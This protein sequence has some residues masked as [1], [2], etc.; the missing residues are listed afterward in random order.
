MSVISTWSMT[1]VD[2]T[3]VANLGKDMIIETLAKDGIIPEDDVEI[4]QK[5]YA[6]IVIKPS[7]LTRLWRKAKG[8]TEYA[9]YRV[10]KLDW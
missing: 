5:R 6:V 7:H 3:E 1:E 4:L 9:S 2:L 10:V 8:E